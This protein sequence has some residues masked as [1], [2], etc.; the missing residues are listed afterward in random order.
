MELLLK[1]KK[2]MEH[3]IAKE[4]TDDAI[5]IGFRN[6]CNAAI[7]Y[8]DLYIDSYFNGLEKN[9]PREVGNEANPSTR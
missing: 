1:L 4:Q 7:N 6:G 3:L 5:G 9:W 2:D 8:I